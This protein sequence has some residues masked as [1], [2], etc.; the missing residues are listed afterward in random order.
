MVDMVSVIKSYSC[1]QLWLT[2]LYPNYENKKT[3]N[4][5]NKTVKCHSETKSR[6]INLSWKLLKVY[7]EQFTCCIFPEKQFERTGS[8]TILLDGCYFQKYFITKGV[9][10]KSYHKNGL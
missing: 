4:V 8:E 6:R 2:E 5:K 10:V 3:I 7:K 1:K 9:I